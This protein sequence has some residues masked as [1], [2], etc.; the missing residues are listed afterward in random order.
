MLVHVRRASVCVTQIASFFYEVPLSKATGFFFRYGQSIGLITN[1]HVLAGRHPATRIPFDPDHRC[2]SRIE[3]HVTLHDPT[4]NQLIFQPLE[5][6]L[7]AEDGSAAWWQHSGYRDHHG[8]MQNIDIAVY[9]LD[10]LPEFGKWQNQVCAFEPQ[11]LV[12]LNESNQPTSVHNAYAQAGAEVFILGY[13]RGL[14]SQGAIPIWKRG[15]IASEPTLPVEGNLPIFFVDA[16]TRHGMSGAPVLY[17][18]EYLVD[19]KGGQVKTHNDRENPWLLGVYA[20]RRGSAD[21]ET[22][23]TIGRAWHRS[24]LDE[25]FMKQIPGGTTP[26]N[27]TATP[28]D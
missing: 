16:A 21:H 10:R 19:A 28:R 4:A 26:G 24:L 12:A 3:C 20:G 14:A 7:A 23:M 27:T 22:E 11:V 25:I 17:T 13:P 6:E 18:G 15:S 9:P 5:L 2:P 8:L 1:W